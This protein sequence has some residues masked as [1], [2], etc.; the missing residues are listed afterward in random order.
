MNLT[1][2]GSV[3]GATTATLT[4]TS[5]QANQARTYSVL[6]WNAAGSATSSN[7]TLAIIT[8]PLI[9]SQPVNQTVVAGATVTFNAAAIGSGTLTY[10]WRFN[11]TNLLDLGNVRGARTASLIL[12]NVQLTQAGNYSVV[13]SNAQGVAASSS[14]LLGVTPVLTLGAA[15]DAPSLMWN[16]APS[17]P[18]L[19]QTNVT[20]DRVDAARSSGIANNRTTWL[21]TAVEGPAT[22][23]FWWKVS[24][25][26]NHDVLL[27]V[28]N[29]MERARISGEVEW[30]R[31]TFDLPAGHQVLRW[32]YSKDSN[33]AIGQDRAWLDEVEF[34]PTFGPTAPIITGQP[35]SSEAA[36]GADLTFSVAASGAAPL[37]YQWQFNGLDLVEGDTVS[38]ATS[39]TLTL[40][41]V[42]PTQEG[43]YRVVVR[44]AYSWAISSNA[45]LA[46][47]PVITLAEALDTPGLLWRNG[48]N[49][50]W[51][52][53]S[54]VNHD[55]LDAAQSG[56]LLDGQTNWIETTVS[57][58]AAVTFWWK[59]SSEAS[60]DRLR[61]YVNGVEQANISGEMG[62]VWRT[63]DLTN[64]TQVVRWAYMKDSR[65]VAGLDRGWVD[66][67]QFGPLAPVITRQAVTQ[68]ADLGAMVNFSVSDSSFSPTDYQWRLNG[69]NLVDGTN[70]IGATQGRLLLPSA[71]PAQAGTY[72]VMLIN[73]GGRALSANAFLSVFPGQP[74]AQ[75]LNTSTN[76]WNTGWVT[77]GDAPWST[78]TSV[79]HDGAKAAQSGAVGDNQ[80]SWLET[81]VVGPGK[82]SFWWRVSS[83]VNTITPG[84]SD[85]NLRFYIS[86]AEQLRISGNVN[87]QSNVFNV[88]NGIQVLHW[89]YQKNSTLA[90]GQDRGWLDQV[91]IDPT[92]PPVLTTKPASLN[93]DPG[94]TAIFNVAA[95]GTLPLGYQ[96][97]F[98]GTSLIDGNGVSGATT[99]SLKLS[100]V[101]PSQ[102]GAYTVAVSNAAAIVTSS[103]AFL[104]VT[105]TVPLAEAL[106][107]PG[108]IWTT[109]GSAPPWLGQVAV[110]HDGLDAARNGIIGDG[111][112]NSIQTT[113]TG[114]ALLS[115]WWKVSSETNND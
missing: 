20:H 95:D 87:W 33:A 83:E 53:Q 98:N 2:G 89:R 74:L 69:I 85:D 62:W 82:V 91:Q 71:Q 76:V 34:S 21:E 4:L 103:N 92:L 14:A 9:T 78:Q 19:P 81:T 30:Q 67:V 47:L 108:W 114:P 26:P 22:L 97:Q 40:L 110:H 113:V 102:A 45:A 94:G 73:A 49:S 54:A 77:G 35:A 16:T 29:G 46:V 17:A 36:P 99:S 68:S 41:N 109:G 96:W 55:W 59:V 18:W 80:R 11:G 38:G 84:G 57:G 64:A 63:F 65:G 90:A 23:S 60:H 70:L 105:P 79:T 112:S 44:N 6:V 58:P 25:R 50:P 7:A 39:P 107:T 86:G 111:A 52:G 61:F 66:E 8:A 28:V 88:S 31:Q 72:S 106:D 12:A 115:F 101:Q 51:L 93:T 37:S 13:V 104:S 100:N 32:A 24:S 43:T 15:L 3:S 75:A 56:A 5:V 48:G 1:D 27:F 42:Q 10:Q